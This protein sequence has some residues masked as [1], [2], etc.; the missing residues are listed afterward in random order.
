MV[1]LKHADS[2]NIFC[3]VVSCILVMSWAQQR[4]TAAFDDKAF[5]YNL[6]VFTVTQCVGYFFQTAYTYEYM[7]GI[8][9]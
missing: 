2:Q 8:H 1:I 3:L 7:K 5:A 4:D 9:Y 6:I